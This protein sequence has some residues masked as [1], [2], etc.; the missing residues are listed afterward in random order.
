[1]EKRKIIKKAGAIILGF[2]IGGGIGLI[3]GEN[4]VD[5]TSRVCLVTRILN[6]I[7]SPIKTEEGY[8]IPTGVALHQWKEMEK[9][10]KE[11]R[12]INDAKISYGKIQEKFQKSILI[13]PSVH[14]NED[15]TIVYFAPSGYDL[16]KINGKVMCQK[17]SYEYGKSGYGL[18][19]DWGIVKDTNGNEYNGCVDTLIVTR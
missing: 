1:M 6:L 8:T 14:V 15:G 4:D 16:V 17:I 12:G 9:D 2:A 13:E 3:I 10:F 5:H 7:P 11:K 18:K 19:A